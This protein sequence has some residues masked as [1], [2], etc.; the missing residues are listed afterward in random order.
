MRG[1]G[2]EVEREGGHGRERYRKKWRV[3]SGEWRMKIRNNSSGEWALRGNIQERF[4][5]CV[6]RRVHGK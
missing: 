1:G 4:L 6:D 5:R 3:A 2:G